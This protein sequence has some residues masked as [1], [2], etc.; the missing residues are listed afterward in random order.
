MGFCFLFFINQNLFIYYCRWHGQNHHWKWDEGYRHWDMCQICSAHSRGQFPGH[1]ASIR[2]SGSQ[3]F[4]LLSF[5]FTFNLT[6]RW[7]HITICVPHHKLLV[8]SGTDWRKPDP[9]TADSW[10]H[11]VRGGCPW[12][13]ARPG[14]CAWAVSFWPRP[15]RHHYVEKHHARLGWKSNLL[16]HF[17]WHLQVFHDRLSLF[18]YKWLLMFFQNKGITSENSWPT[19]SIVLMTM[20]HSCIMEGELIFRVIHIQML[21]YLTEICNTYKYTSCTSHSG[22]PSLKMVDQQLSP[23]QILMFPL[24]S[25]MDPVFSI[26]TRSTF[27]TTVVG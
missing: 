13:N 7:W 1:P 16:S 12:I 20:A 2:V 17:F 22:M 15:V 9:V 19:I 21:C 27:C 14:L 4:Q 6:S 3:W 26:F 23:S 8:I 25:E 11:V 18:E 10:L 5:Y 24:A